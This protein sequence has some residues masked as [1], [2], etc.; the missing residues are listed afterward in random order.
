M[1]VLSRPIR[2][3]KVLLLLASLGVDQNSITAFRLQKAES[4]RKS[5]EMLNSIDFTYLSDDSD[6]EPAAAAG[7]AA[8]EGESGEDDENELEEE[9][10]EPPPVPNALFMFGPKNPNNPTPTAPE[11]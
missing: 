5:V 6:Q 9:D 1:S 2:P 4:G 11:E 8:G 3:S 7:A 10:T